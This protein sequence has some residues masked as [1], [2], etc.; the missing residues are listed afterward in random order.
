MGLGIK[1]TLTDAQTDTLTPWMRLDEIRIAQPPGAPM[2]KSDLIEKIAAQ[3]PHLY[4]QGTRRRSFEHL[5]GE[6]KHIKV[7]AIVVD[8]PRA[9]LVL[10]VGRAGQGRPRSTRG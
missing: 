8:R 6:Y 3:N 1:P 7:R 9:I 4:R 5:R 10:R 2:L